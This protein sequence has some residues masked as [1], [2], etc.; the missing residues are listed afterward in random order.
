[1]FEFRTLAQPT[2]YSRQAN[3]RDLQA[4]APTTPLPGNKVDDEFNALKVTTDEVRTNLALI[5]RDDGQLANGSVGR[6]QLSSSIEI[7]IN[8]ATEWETG[9]E[10][11]VNS[12]VVT[13]GKFY[14]CLEAHTSGVFATDLAAEKWVFQFDFG[15]DAIASATSASAAATSETNAA[16]SASAA[17]TSAS[18]AAASAASVSAVDGGRPDSNYTSTDPFDGGAP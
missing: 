14:R 1:M 13:G 15:A 6:D 10:Y 16:T 11:T 7:G 4:L 12:N 18:E 9:R 2:E 8:P 17:A 5:Q 3:F